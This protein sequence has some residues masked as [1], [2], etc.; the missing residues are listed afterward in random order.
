[1][2]RKPIY[3][4]LF[5]ICS[6]YSCGPKTDQFDA[7]GTFEA[8]EIIV[9]SEIAGRILSFSVEEGQTL[10]KGAV[11]GTIDAENIEL[12]KEQVQ[13]SINA[14]QDKTL[15]VQPQINL[16][17][18]QL[19][20][21]Q[22]QLKT[23]DRERQRTENLLKADVATGKQLD[24]INSQIEALKLQMNVTRQQISVQRNSINTQNRSILSE[25][26]PLQK[27]VEQLKDQLDKANI[28]NPV[29]GT[30]ISKYAEEGE[31]TSPGKA[32]YK[33]ADL[34]TLNLQ[35]YITGNQ[36]SQVKLNQQVTVLVDSADKY[37]ELPG[38]I[39]WISD[40][41]E[42]TPKTIQTKDERA[43][44]V[45]AVKIRVKNDG[46]LKLGMYGEVKLNRK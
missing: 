43:N 2:N 19:R 35:A 6:F 27:R 42:F 28:T 12:Q 13:S 22:S 24:D 7:T 34:S 18:D 36:L 40:Q 41:A 31:I 38:T 33:M 32:L 8:D 25:S 21:Q 14:L 5:L 37:K 11:V 23:L 44:L 10:E 45:Y 1:M 39:T 29:K 46:Y 15:N 16:L 4:L 9:S 30:V 26:K 17:N 3:T 20:V